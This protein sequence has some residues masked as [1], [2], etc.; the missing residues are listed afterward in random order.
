[1]SVSA[2]SQIR[3]FGAGPNPSAYFTV[4]L[5]AERISRINGRPVMV[6]DAPTYTG[7]TGATNVAVVGDFTSYII[8]MRQGLSIEPVPMLFQQQTAG[9]GAG[10]PTGQRGFFAWFLRL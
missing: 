10:F 8:A 3:S 6:T 5:T 7:A 4:D 2:E 1:M 9:T